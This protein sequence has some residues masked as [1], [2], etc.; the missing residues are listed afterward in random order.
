MLREQ[1]DVVACESISNFWV[2][3]YDC[4]TNHLTVIV[5]N[6]RDMKAYT[7][8]KTDKID[9]EFIAQFAL[10]GMIKPSRIH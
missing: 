1:C 4:L 9:A 8:K 6:A 5:G 7:Y 2:S 10:N 3:I